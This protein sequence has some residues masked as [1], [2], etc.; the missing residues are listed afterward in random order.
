MDVRMTYYKRFF[1]TLS[2]V[3][4]KTTFDKVLKISVL[5][6]FLYVF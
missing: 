1:K 2:K 6:N 5:R 4:L 3:I